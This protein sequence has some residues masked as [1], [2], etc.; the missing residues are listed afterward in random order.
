MTSIGVPS[1]ANST[2]PSAATLGP[3]GKC[4][5]DV[6]VRDQAN[7]PISG[8]VVVVEFGSCALAFCAN[9]P[10][11]VVVNAGANTAR[12]VTDASGQAHV[13]VCVSNQ[14][15][16][17]TATL[18]ADGIQLCANIPTQSCPSDTACVP[19]QWHLVADAGPGPRY[20]SAMASDYNFEAIIEFGGFS[21]G[22]YV[23]D[24]WR[25][26]GYAWSQVS[27]PTS[28]GPRA[29]HA[30]AYDRSRS[31]MVMFGGLQNGS[32]L[33]DT[34][35]FDG[36]AWSQVAS[37]GPVARYGH[38]MTYDES[39][40]RIVLFGGR[41]SVG[42]SDLGD[43]WEW[44]GTSWTQTATTGPSPRHDLAMAYDYASG[45]TM[46]YGGTG[47]GGDRGDLWVYNG[48]GWLE[49][50]QQSPNPGIRTG[51][52]MAFSAEG[53][54]MVLYGGLGAGADASTWRW[55][56]GA[57][58][59]SVPGVG[60]LIQHTMAYDYFNEHI[61]VAGG[62]QSATV[63]PALGITSE[64]CSPC[65]SVAALEDSLGNIIW[66]ADVGPGE[67]ID[68]T[69]V[70]LENGDIK[71]VY[72]LLDTST[73]QW[74]DQ[75]PC[76]P[77]FGGEADSTDFV[78]PFTDESDSLGLD[79]IPEQEL[80][81]SLTAWQTRARDLAISEPP[82]FGDSLAAAGPYHAPDANYCPNRNFSYAFGGR[83][84]IF[85]H[86]YRTTPIRE[87]MF[88][89]SEA[90][91]D[92]AFV[93]WIPTNGAP[94]YI[95]NPTFYG[96]LDNYWS[97]GA[98]K[99][100]QPH[101]QRFLT[102]NHYMNRYLIVS[103]SSNQRMAV[104][105]Q[106]ILTQISDAMREGKGVID[107]TGVNGTAKFGTPDF[108]VVSHSTGGPITDAALGSARLLPS[109]HAGFIA[110]H[111]KAHIAIAAAFSGSAEATALLGVSAAL[112]PQ[113]WQCRLIQYIF[114][115]HDI[116][117]DHFI[118]AT[119]PF[120]GVTF[121]LAPPVMQY[122]WG[123]YINA[124]PTRTVTIAGG[125]PSFEWPI[126]RL[127]LRGQDD[128]VV[129]MNSQSANPLP[130]CDWPSGYLRLGPAQLAGKAVKDIYLNEGLKKRRSRGY[131]RDQLKDPKFGSV[132]DSLVCLPGDF[133][134]FFTRVAS[135]VTDKLSPTGM[136]QP[137]HF[138]AQ[139]GPLDPNL[140]YANHYSFIESAADHFGLTPNYQDGVA[141]DA[142]PDC[143]ISR[144]AQSGPT[145][146]Y[147]AFLSN[148]YL[149]THDFFFGLLGD[150][151]NMEETLVINDPTIYQPYS[152][153]GDNAAL[154]NMAIPKVKDGLTVDETVRQK[155][156]KRSGRP[157]KI[158]KH[159]RI[160]HRLRN[161]EN[162][163]AA[164]Y[165]YD[166]LLLDPPNACAA[167]VGVAAPAVQVAFARS[168]PNPFH[169]QLSIEF[170]TIER[171]QVSLDIYDAL[172]R[173][174][175]TLLS[176]TLIPGQRTLLWDARAD[177]GKAVPVGLYLWRLRVDGREIGRHKVLL[178]H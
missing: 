34:W 1:P 87:K 158:F 77:S 17:C 40:G 85:I 133:G 15:P 174:V 129:N 125:H 120:T 67:T 22:A 86:G 166:Y 145:E 138:A 49:L 20:G 114:G 5:F 89:D 50:T 80:T 48:T 38:S 60:P 36:A 70:T 110:D 96:G 33:A 139:G 162:R 69:E 72:P 47:A 136:V 58:M 144:K 116:V 83:D 98:V 21:F 55:N 177:D 134:P 78:D 115:D 157:R 18:S 42:G 121:D 63:D 127:L 143:C 52:A 81:D 93:D 44:D 109:L 161:W 24:T 61:M 27:G 152:V 171:G 105:I 103:W 149:P 175:R 160:Y 9:Q 168:S 41:S 119:A 117:C 59:R 76:D 73:D 92:S 13:C 147:N 2:C 64:W 170:R 156:H 91:C 97:R 19:E 167:G 108:V 71:S 94:G 164:D 130:W 26:D 8:S 153:A 46:L 154:I 122:R 118:N 178:L 146:G 14:P 23:N 6:I 25:W 163:M 62:R 102:D 99:Y 16:L 100:W 82:P 90:P 75:M 176:Q 29:Y 150:Q 148:K 51:H 74:Y 106:A 12:V 123:S 53:N 66:P 30:M 32:V 151:Q 10:L 54:T 128:G 165:A 141:L 35:E 95:L 155:V 45:L 84:I 79:G 68:S 39:R 28:P 7:N 56:G 88:H 57:W 65:P 172:G 124:S 135:G 104:G 43:T 142:C 112:A 3:D 132:L 37:T 111:A 137:R 140:R 159:K 11:G 101:I 169:G 107:P 31:R 126:K 173:H 113:A 4:C 131:F